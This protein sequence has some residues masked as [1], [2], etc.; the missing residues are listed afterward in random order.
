MLGRPEVNAVDAERRRGLGIPRIVV[1]E[2]RLPGIDAIAV[3]ENAED[4]CIGLDHAFFAG[5]DNA[6]EPRQEIE[7]LALGR[8]VSADQLVSA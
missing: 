1:D 6:V 8:D 5:N 3:E 2:Y 4:A 7:T